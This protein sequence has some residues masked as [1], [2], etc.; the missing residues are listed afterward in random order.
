[1]TP[2]Q[3]AFITFNCAGA[4]IMMHRQYFPVMIQQRFGAT[5]YDF[6]TQAYQ[7]GVFR[8]L[9]DII[10]KPVMDGHRAYRRLA[11]ENPNSTKSARFKQSAK[12]FK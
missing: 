3:K 7:I 10:G 4:L 5:V 2:A 11:E 1:M 8:A 9:L 6:D 12:M